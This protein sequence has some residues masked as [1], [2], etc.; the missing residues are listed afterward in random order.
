MSFPSDRNESDMWWRKSTYDGWF[1]NA[2][3][4]FGWFI[5]T[6]IMFSAKEIMPAIRF[7]TEHYGVAIDLFKDGERVVNDKANFKADLKELTSASYGR[8]YLL[9]TSTPIDNRAKYLEVWE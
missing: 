7:Q 8:C 5:A 9:T 3:L 4:Y 6:I 2:L 1:K